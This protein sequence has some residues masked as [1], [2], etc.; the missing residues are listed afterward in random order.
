MPEMSFT[1]SIKRLFEDLEKLFTTK[2]VFGDP[3]TVGDITII[4][5]IDI[6]FG[7]GIGGGT[8]EDKNKGG[9]SGGG[10]GAGGR[11]SA[12]AVIVVRGEQVQVMQIKNSSN[13]GKLVDMLPDIVNRFKQGK[14]QPE[15]NPAG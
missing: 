2:T 13:L 5:V 14:D 6:T 3:V 4:P 10:G 11:V 7:L 8:G 12:S 1:D 15:E 9:G